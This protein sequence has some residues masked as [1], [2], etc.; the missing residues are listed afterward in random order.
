MGSE[1]AD[2]VYYQRVDEVKRAIARGAA[3]K[4]WSTRF[5]T[6]YGLAWDAK[7]QV[8]TDSEG[9]AYDGLR[10]GPRRPDAA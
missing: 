7:R 10:F 8:W 2:Y 1:D 6:D 9:F 4:A 5:E 3:D